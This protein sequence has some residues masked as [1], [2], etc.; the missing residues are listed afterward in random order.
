MIGNSFEDAVKCYEKI[1]HCQSK[2]GLECM[3]GKAMRNA[4]EISH[5]HLKKY[6]RASDY[7]TKAAS[8]YKEEGDEALEKEC[9]E[10]AEK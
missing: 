10:R 4:A 9:L 1:S 6:E 2:V 7:Y 5:V 3:A 8:H